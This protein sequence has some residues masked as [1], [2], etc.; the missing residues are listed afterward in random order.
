VVEK[1][2]SSVL[3]LNSTGFGI[4]LTFAVFWLCFVNFQPNAWCRKICLAAFQSATQK[5]E[6]HYLFD[7]IFLNKTPTG[8]IWIRYKGFKEELPEDREM[9]AYIYFR[10]NYSIYPRKIY[11]SHPSTII[12]NSK[13]MM[14]PKKILTKSLSKR[15][16]IRWIVT[17]I[18]NE[19]QLSANI[20]KVM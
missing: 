5:V 4:L 12:N 10:G 19:G 13:K 2:T 11:V 6:T 16:K 17:F 14:P 1:K 9:M 7:D 15:L 8:N 18:S 20:I 3:K